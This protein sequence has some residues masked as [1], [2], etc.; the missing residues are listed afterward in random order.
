MV[1]NYINLEY[2]YLFLLWRT[3]TTICDEWKNTVKYCFPS[4]RVYFYEF[5][6]WT[7]HIES[8]LYTTLMVLLLPLKV[9]QGGNTKANACSDYVEINTFSSTVQN[10]NG[11]LWRRNLVCD[12][13]NYSLNFI[14]LFIFKKMKTSQL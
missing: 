11:L 1:S 4:I 9:I 7:N 13:L 6:G 3:W 5:Y 10:I 14:K 2:F 12:C 8:H